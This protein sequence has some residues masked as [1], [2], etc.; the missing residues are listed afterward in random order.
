M[1]FLLLASI[2]ERF[3]RSRLR[4]RPLPPHFFF[5]I[6]KRIFFLL[7]VNC[8]FFRSIARSLASRHARTYLLTRVKDPRF[9]AVIYRRRIYFETRFQI[10]VIRHRGARRVNCEFLYGRGF[11]RPLFSSTRRVAPQPLLPEPPRGLRVTH[12]LPSIH[13]SLRLF[14]TPARVDLPYKVSCRRTLM[15]YKMTQ[16][17][18]RT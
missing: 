6:K 9:T 13:S 5:I 11:R 2:P 12:A 14:I 1:N 16:T 18:A 7:R 3:P 17:V 15:A 4:V 10:R 8:A